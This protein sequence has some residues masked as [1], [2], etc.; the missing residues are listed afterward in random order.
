MLVLMFPAMLP[1]IVVIGAQEPVAILNIV[2]CD[3]RIK[4][5]FPGK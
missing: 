3:M 1:L 4:E 5:T 2:S